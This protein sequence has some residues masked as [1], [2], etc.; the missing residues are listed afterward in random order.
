MNLY[1]QD[2][3]ATITPYECGLGWTVVL[4]GGRDF[5]GRAALARRTP[6]W[7]QLGL[8]LLA[9]GVMRGHQRVQ[10]AHGEGMI[11]SGSFSPTLGRSIALARLP[12][13]AASGDNVTVEVRGRALAARVVK[14][15][16]ARRG[17]VRIAL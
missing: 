12:P 9:S 6:R 2:M 17:A 5:V 3:D 14:P 1:G 15:P 16:F 7:Q 8:V 13:P 11:T 10:T 4:A